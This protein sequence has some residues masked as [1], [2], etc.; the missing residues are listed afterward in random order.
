MLACCRNLE[1]G[2]TEL[3]GNE[4]VLLDLICKAYY[5]PQWCSIN[6]Y[7]EIFEAEV[8]QVCYLATA[9]SCRMVHD[10]Q[11]WHD[12]SVSTMFTVT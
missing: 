5:L 8:L 10:L 9:Q 3:R 2:E 11:L 4:K 7:I 12:T 1:A 6:D